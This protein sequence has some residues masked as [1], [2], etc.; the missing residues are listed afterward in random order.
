MG[1][2]DMAESDKLENNQLTKLPGRKHITGKRANNGGARRGSGRR[3]GTAN[4]RTRDIANK[5]AEDGELTPLEYLL[6]VMRETS[7]KLKAQYETGEIDT[8]EYADKLR[9]LIKRRDKAAEIAAPYIH[10]RLASVQSSITDVEHERWLMMI[11]D[12]QREF[13]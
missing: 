1:A 12:A 11:E 3:K 4:I 5:L 7:E 9:E 2:K 6:G 10:P 8:A 13:T